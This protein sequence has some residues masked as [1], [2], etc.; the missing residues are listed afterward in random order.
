LSGASLSPAQ[1]RLVR[2][3]V[4]D[5]AEVEGVLA[6]AL[7]GSHARGRAR[8]DSDVDLGILYA[9]SAPFS[10]E[11]L[12]ARA[13][14]WSDASDAVVTGFYEW[15]PW[16][17]G[18]AW[19]T[20]RGQRVD[21]LYRSVEHLE[22]ALADGEAG[23]HAVHHGQQPPFGFWSGTA[24]GELVVGVPLHD[25][26][27]RLAELRARIARYPER[28]RRAVVA[29]G[30]WAVEFG[31]RAFAP[32]YAAAGDVYGTAG[33]LTRFAH[34]LVLVLFAL[35]R[36]WLVNDKTALAEVAGFDAAPERFGER[37]SAV[38]ARPGTTPGEL[39]ASVAGLAG[40]FRETRALAGDLYA[41]R[42]ALPGEV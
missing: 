17:N 38:L 11:A 39:G 33:C 13:A 21:L 9:E 31:L 16:V 30:L 15:G 6:V 4:A 1:E 40:L 26:S 10:I 8:P 28:L 29:D 34:Q 19:L 27:G 2:E 23:R 36:A 20:C 14:R 42:F 24:L 18:G 25:P 12:R 41:P 5:L 7:G 35:N 22:R 32:K 3:V 37:V